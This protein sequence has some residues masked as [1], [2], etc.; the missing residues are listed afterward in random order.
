MI[1]KGLEISQSQNPKMTAYGIAKIY[2]TSYPNLKDAL[3]GGRGFSDEM[4]TS[5]S[6]CPE[7]PYSYSELKAVQAVEE[8]GDEDILL[9][10]AIKKYGVEGLFKEVEKRIKAKGGQ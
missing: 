6:K 2:G 3:D 8:F 10:A 9:Q 5:L 7:F 1:K 4:L